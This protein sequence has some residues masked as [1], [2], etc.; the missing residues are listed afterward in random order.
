[1]R[2]SLN[3][4]RT[5]LAQAANIIE[6]YRLHY[7]HPDALPRSVDT[8]RDL[9]Q[10]HEGKEVNVLKSHL[11]AQKESV[12]GHY[13]AYDDHYDVV[14]LS[15][16]NYC[17]ERFVLCKELFHVV[18]DSDE[19]RN[20]HIGELVEEYTVSWPADINPGPNVTNEMVAEICAMEF[21][22]P[23]ADRVG[24]ISGSGYDSGAI[25]ERYRVPKVFIE[26]YLSA[27]YM[28]NLKQ[29]FLKAAA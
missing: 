14:I 5:C 10:T 12:K 2:I 23:Y 6:I 24:Y 17:W 29:F 18:I 11:D 7:P 3:D 8:L 4:L 19:Y 15:G 22:F 20:V 13:V 27:A 16:L 1:M 28:A 26:R 9:L 21:L 25:A